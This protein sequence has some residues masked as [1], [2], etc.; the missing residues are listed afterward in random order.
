MPPMPPP[1][2]PPQVA[3][4]WDTNRKLINAREI[5]R[6]GNELFMGEIIASGESWLDRM[7]HLGFI[8]QLRQPSRA[9][10]STSMCQA[11]LRRGGVRGAAVITGV[12][13]S[14]S[15]FALYIQY[16]MREFNSHTKRGH[17]ARA[18]QQGARES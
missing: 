3:Q 8:E 15:V 11:R 17:G 1:P 5:V 18:G 14:H 16:F 2:P 10:Q 13:V 4:V 6:K 12:R 9:I 7:V